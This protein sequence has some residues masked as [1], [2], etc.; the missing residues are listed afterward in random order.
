MIKKIVTGVT[1]M[2]LGSVILANN[3]VV[4]K[5]IKIKDAKFATCYTQTVTQYQNS[6]GEYVRSE[7]GLKVAVTCAPGQLEGSTTTTC[8]V[9]QLVEIDTSVK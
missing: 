9:A 5:N 2:G 4:I 6:K 8:K 3:H 7:V 1:L